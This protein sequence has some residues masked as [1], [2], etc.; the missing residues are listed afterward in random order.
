[1]FIAPSCSL[2]H[3]PVD[4]DGETKLDST[5][6]S[7]MAFAKQ[8]V[9]AI[10]LIADALNG[11]SGQTAK[12]LDANAKAMASRRASKRIH[13]PAVAKRSASVTPEMAERSSPYPERRKAQLQALRLPA[14][15]TTTI[16]SFP[17]TPEIRKARA[18]HNKGELTG[19]EYEA[20]HQKG[21]RAQRPFPGADG[22]RCPRARRA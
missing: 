22:T 20:I 12:E 3:S 15:P 21:D 16:G 1:M 5:M 7:W 10:A 14:F 13:N 8:K 11:K 2:L 6:K 17:Q 19:P 18:S 4:L 9:S